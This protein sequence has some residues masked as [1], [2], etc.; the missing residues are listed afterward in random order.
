MLCCIAATAQTDLKK[1]IVDS[2][3]ACLNEIPDISKK[4]PEELQVAMSQCMM[5]KSMEDVIALVQE[6]NIEMTDMEG[7]QKLMAEISSDLVK[8]DC[9]ALTTMMLKMAGG[10]TAGKDETAP[11]VSIKGAVQKVETKDFVY[12]TVLSGAKSVQLVWSDYVTNGDVYAKDLMKLKSKDLQFYFTTK[13]VYS[14]AAKAYIN[15]KMI[16]AI[17]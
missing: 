1:K 4:T 2:T 11:A 15:V 8:S 5:K 3:C 12:I 6:R 13:D 10:N 9:K 17:K 14:P 16:T 7:M